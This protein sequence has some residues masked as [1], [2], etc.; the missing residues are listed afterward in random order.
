[1]SVICSSRQNSPANG[2]PMVKNVSQGST[3]ARSSRMEAF[4]GGIASSVT[5]CFKAI[6]KLNRR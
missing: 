6:S 3:R 1:M 5:A 2:L 4:E